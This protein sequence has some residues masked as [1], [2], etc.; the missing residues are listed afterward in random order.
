VLRIRLK[1]VVY[2]IKRCCVLEKRFRVLN[3]H[4]LCIQLQDVVY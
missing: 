4:M 2:K 3:E 1:D